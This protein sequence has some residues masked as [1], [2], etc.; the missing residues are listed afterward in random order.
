MGLVV[1]VTGAGSGLG[2]ALAVRLAAD[3]TRLILVGRR[4]GR[5]RETRD[6]CVAGGGKA[7]DIVE[8]PLDLTGPDAAAAVAEAATTAFDGLDALVNNAAQAR[9]GALDRTGMATFAGLL[10]VNLVAPA[11]LSQA[12]APLLRRSRGTIVNV[13]SIGGLLAVPGRS[14]YG[15]AKA[16]LHHLTRSLARE[17]APD[18]RVNAVLPGAVDTEMYDDLGIDD[19]DVARLRTEMVRTTP[20]G[21]M[22]RPEDVVPWI[23][24]LLG[25]AAAWM[26]GSL[27]VVD[28][29][30]SC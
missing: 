24:M 17:L 13:G 25:P 19:D 5:L 14:Y 26:T 3:G 2:R 7:G 30:R 22:G 18:I 10:Q 21:R 4:A 8:L 23:V 1:A 27:L 11:A 20:L 6:A 15:A 29:G 28:G 9:F 16:G 12:V